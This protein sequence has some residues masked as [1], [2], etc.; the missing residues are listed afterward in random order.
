MSKVNSNY[1]DIHG[2][3]FISQ[4]PRDLKGSNKKEEPTRVNRSSLHDTF[5]AI[6]GDSRKRAK[7][8]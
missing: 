6:S 4:L 5:M 7:I 3:I 2:L 8:S 1:M